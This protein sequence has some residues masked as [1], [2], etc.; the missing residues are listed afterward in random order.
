MPPGRQSNLTLNTVGGIV[1]ISA[2]LTIVLAFWGH[3]WWLNGFYDSDILGRWSAS[4]LLTDRNKYGGLTNNPLDRPEA[5]RG[6][7]IVLLSVMHLPGL[8]LTAARLVKRR[9]QP[10]WWEAA[11]GFVVAWYASLLWATLPGRF[12]DAPLERALEYSITDIVE[13]VARSA[14]IGAALA[15][16]VLAAAQ[17]RTPGQRA[18]RGPILLALPF[19]VVLPFLALGHEIVFG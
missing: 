17:N 12:S 13:A 19:A 2:V 3:G 9:R 6:Y 15:F 4:Q 10:W 16:A 8:V 1:L 18:P 5:W 14:A 7:A 11:N